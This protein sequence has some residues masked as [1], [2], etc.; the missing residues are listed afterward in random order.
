MAITDSAAI[1]VIVAVG[2]QGAFLAWNAYKITERGNETHESIGLFLLLMAFVHTIII[3]TIARTI[4]AENI[5]SDGVV[6]ALTLNYRVA[7]IVFIIV[8]VYFT[9]RVMIVPMLQ[10]N[11]RKK[12]TLKED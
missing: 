5:L 6:A 2:M 7:I 9:L 11:K 8:M 3:S 1:A 10:A 12:F 4:A